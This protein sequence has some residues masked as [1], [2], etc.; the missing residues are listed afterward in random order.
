[1]EGGTIFIPYQQRFQGNPIVS[2]YLSTAFGAAIGICVAGVAALYVN[3]VRLFSTPKEIGLGATFQIWGYSFDL[4]TFFLISTAAVL[5]LLIRSYFKISRW[6]GPADAIY[7][8]HQDMQPLDIKTGFASTLAALVSA[9]GSASVGQY[10]PLV[11]FGATAGTALKQW[12]RLPMKSDVVIGCGVAAAIS[13]GFN[14]PIAGIIFAHE[15]ILRHF[16]SRAMAPIATSAIVAAAMVNFVFHLP[17]PL[18][19]RS[20]A[21]TLMLSFLPVVI[22]GVLFGLVAVAFMQSMRY[23][24]RLNGRL[25]LKTYQSLIV[26]VIAVTVIGGFF[27]Q[28]LGLGTVALAEVLNIPPS[29]GFAAALLVFKILLTSICLGF[30]FFGG[31]FS[32]SLLIGAAAGAVFAK[33][34]DKIG[35]S[36]LN[37][38][39]ALAGMASVA[40]CVVGAPLATIFIVL[41]LT[42]SYEFT[43][44]TLLAVVVS[45]VVSINIFGHSFFD[46]QLLDRGIDLQFGRGQLSL[47]Q[48][49]VKTYA[50]DRFVSVSQDQ[51]AATVMQMLRAMDMTEAYCTRSDGYFE[52]KVTINQLLGA[53]HEALIKDVLTP[54]PV[55]LL[56]SHSMLEA[57]EI[58]SGFVGES[59]PVLDPE[60]H[61]MA[62]VVTEADLFEAY[63]NIQAGIQE[64]EKS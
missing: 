11:H 61:Q 5:I 46:R 17:H 53:R 1:M 44:I 59:I 48:T 47:T 27:P 60:T 41:E 7:A 10:G 52:G 21:P 55:S 45:Q 19:L 24:A 33:A 6:N 14:A 22:S 40:A 3:L 51:T 28:T 9:C 36:D 50:N 8:A 42:L 30:G 37:T 34:F 16:S 25:G 38:A 39:L 29:L 13:A 15:A 4:T 31:V 32:P 57:I 18:S 35:F 23:L 2:T 64:V 63:L 56:T 49:P 62:G 54:Q 20:Q 12:I 26:A 58:A 43:L